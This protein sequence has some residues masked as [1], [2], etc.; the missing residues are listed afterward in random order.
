MIGRPTGFT[1]AV[2]RPDGERAFL[3]HLG[4]QSSYSLKHDERPLVKEIQAEDIV[5]FSGYF[6]QPKLRPETR[7]I[8]EAAKERGAKVSFDPGWDP[9]GFKPR[10][11][12]EIINLLT[13]V[14]FFEPNHS[15]LQAIAGLKSVRGS[16]RR[17]FRYFDGILALKKGNAGSQV[18]AGSK[19]VTKVDAFQLKSAVDSTGAGDAFD[20]GFLHGIAHGRSFMESAHYGNAAAALLIS[21]RRYSTLRFPSNRQVERLIRG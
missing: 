11:R 20:G 2:V 5:H 19:S 3:T 15:E 17:L 6:M 8:I 7:L 14:D 16:V 4:H 21:S 1:V 12:N 13:Q 10:T 9:D 18:F